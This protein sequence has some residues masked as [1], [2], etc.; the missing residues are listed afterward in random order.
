MTVEVYS[1]RYR[2]VPVALSITTADPWDSSEGR[3]INAARGH[4]EGVEFYLHRKMSSSYMYLFS[5]SFYRAFFDDPRTGE[6]RPWDFDHRHVFTASAAK[7]W[8]MTNTQ[9]YQELKTR[10]WYRF[11]GWALPFGDEVM[12]SA[13]WRFVGGRPYT[14]PA[15]LRDFHAWI[16]PGDGRYNTGR[17]PDYHRLDIRLDRRYY[18]K[19]WSFVAY[20]DVMNVYNRKNVWD[21]NRD[22][23]GERESIYQFTT[24]PVGGFNVEF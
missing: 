19:N 21:Y 24:F 17:L 20:L 3:I 14:E 11:V 13:K 1:K 7:R 2:D 6:E 5:Y 16:I 9:W 23:Y 10:W 15:Y 18:F 8:S 4:S 12:L 22:E